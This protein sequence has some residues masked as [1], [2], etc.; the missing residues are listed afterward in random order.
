MPLPRTWGRDRAARRRSRPSAAASLA[1]SLVLAVGAAAFPS[2]AFA[3]DPAVLGQFNV[4]DVG[5]EFT[6][7]H[8]AL[9]RTGK[10]W[11]G[12]GSGNEKST[13]QAGDFRSFVWD[14]VVAGPAQEI[15]APWDLFCAGQTFL[16]NGKLLIAG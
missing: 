2:T 6:P 12:A 15:T 10:V 7:I 13:F 8:A 3:G 16:A 5:L 9:M 11:M 1:F 4:Y 14:P